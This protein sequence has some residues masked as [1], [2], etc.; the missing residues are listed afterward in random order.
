MTALPAEK[1]RMNLR[2]RLVPG[3]FADVTVFDPGTIRDK[4]TY[5]DPIQLSEGVIALLVNGVLEI[6]DGK[7]TGQRGGRALRAL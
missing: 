6:R 5:Q 7:A 2:G 4:A 3:Y 1:F